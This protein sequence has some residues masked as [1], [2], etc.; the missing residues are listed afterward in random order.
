MKYPKFRRG[1]IVKTKFSSKA[2]ILRWFKDSLG[3]DRYEIQYIESKVKIEVCEDDLEFYTDDL[4]ISPKNTSYGDQ[5]PKCSTPW[6]ITYIGAKKCYDCIPCKKKAEDLCSYFGTHGTKMT[7]KKPESD[8]DDL[9]KE[10]EALLGSDDDNDWD[11]W[12]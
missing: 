10:F 1:D 9:L 2:R 12:F 11:D 8:I 5:C 6:T 7:K 4:K 3:R